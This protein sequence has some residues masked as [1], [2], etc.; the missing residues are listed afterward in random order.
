MIEFVTTEKTLRELNELANTKGWELI[1]N[2][3]YN[4]DHGHV[5]V[6]GGGDHTHF[7]YLLRP[8][9]IGAAKYGSHNSTYCGGLVDAAFTLEEM[10]GNPVPGSPERR[11]KWRDMVRTFAPN[12]SVLSNNS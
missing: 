10:F 8:L 11:D 6:L 3:T 12:H 9:T 5:K 7:Q 4:P 2:Q 1:D